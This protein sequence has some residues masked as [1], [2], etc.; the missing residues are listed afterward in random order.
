MNREPVLQEPLSQEQELRLAAA[1]AAQAAAA[2]I[3]PDTLCC[4]AGEL[5]VLLEHL[6]RL[7]RALLRE[8]T[9]E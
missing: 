2:I 8:E 3:D 5:E 6:A 7:N 9:A 1:M 4:R